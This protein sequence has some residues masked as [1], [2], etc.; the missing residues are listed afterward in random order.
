MAK[1]ASLLSA[2]MTD[3]NQETANVPLG[4]LYGTVQIQALVVSMKEIYGWLLM[5]ALVSLLVILVSYGPVRPRAIFPKWKTV[6][7]IFRRIVKIEEW[8]ERIAASSLD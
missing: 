3:F 6:R 2:A 8:A 7:N 5:I 1:N 4:Q